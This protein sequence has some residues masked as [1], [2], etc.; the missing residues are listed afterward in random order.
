MSSEGCFACKIQG[1]KAAAIPNALRRRTHSSPSH[2]KRSR[3]RRRGRSWRHQVHP[4]SES[5]RRRSRREAARSTTI[6]GLSNPRDAF[7]DLLGDGGWRNKRSTEKRKMKKERKSRRRRRRRRRKKD[8]SASASAS[9]PVRLRLR[10]AET[11]GKRRI[12]YIQRARS[13][14]ELSYLVTGRDSPLF[15]LR[16]RDGIWGLY[17]R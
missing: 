1:G 12:L 10:A 6:D 7:F 15:G 4:G 9:E 13:D 11:S 5:R 16:Q 14:V 17:Y 3:K 2:H 8:L